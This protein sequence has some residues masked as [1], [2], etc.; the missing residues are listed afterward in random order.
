MLHTNAYP[1][2]IST[3]AAPD[4]I[5]GRLLASF[6]E[7]SF[8]L[9]IALVILV[10][11]RAQTKTNLSRLIVV[12]DSLSAGFQNESLLDSQQPNGYASL[13]AAQA[14]VPLPLPLIAPP[15]IPNVLTLVSPGPPPVIVPAPG[16]STGRDNPTIQAMDLAVPGANVQD[17]LT[18][19]PSFTFDNLT[20]F[21]LGLPGALEGIS[22]SQ[23]EWA[24][25][26]APTTI[27][28]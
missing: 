23:I 24:E 11:A 13:V 21:V 6:Y 16:V 5:L 14:G 27:F 8:W 28:V 22:R 2:P 1:R 19:R 18:T 3:L 9:M 26:L 17:A 20:D 15:G 25:N 10:P 12:G 4:A 7:V